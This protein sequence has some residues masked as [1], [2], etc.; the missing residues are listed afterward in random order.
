MEHTRQSY[1]W[2]ALMLENEDCYINGDGEN[3]RDFCFIENIIQMNILAATAPETEKDEVYNVALGNRTTLV[4][5]F[6]LIKKAI[7]KSDVFVTSKPVFREFRAG[8]VRHSQADISKAVARL[9]YQP[10]FDVRKGIE[11]TMPWY[12][13]NIAASENDNKKKED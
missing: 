1:Q 4:E 12:I 13:A 6:N 3:S 5:L 11:K 2:T 7:L 9:G 8:D 10:R